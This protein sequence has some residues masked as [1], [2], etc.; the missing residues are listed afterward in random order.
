MKFGSRPGDLLL[1]VTLVQGKFNSVIKSADDQSATIAELER[2]AASK[3]PE[4][5]R[6]AEELRIRQAGIRG[7]RESAYLI[8]FEFAYRA[9]GRSSTTSGSNTK[10]A[11]RRSHG[12][13]GRQ[14]L[15]LGSL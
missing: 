1:R 10:A 4:A 9:T 14:P 6:A 2:I 5:K 11:R 13:D 15:H 7:E 8:Y 12:A 3:A